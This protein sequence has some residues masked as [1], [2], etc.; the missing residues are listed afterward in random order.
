[1]LKILA[2]EPSLAFLNRLGGGTFSVSPA[3]GVRVGMLLKGP[4]GAKGW[5]G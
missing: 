2:L 4:Q 1:V 5:L 3:S